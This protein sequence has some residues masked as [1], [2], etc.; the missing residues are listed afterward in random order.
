MTNQ[1]AGAA[2]A[3]LALLALANVK[4]GL[5]WRFQDWRYG[6]KVDETVEWEAFT[7]AFKDEE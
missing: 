3:L 6:R 4:F 5:W 1:L 2:L 7:A